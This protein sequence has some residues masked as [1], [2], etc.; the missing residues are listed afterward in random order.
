METS[1]SKLS[2][3]EW[4]QLSN[5]WGRGIDWVVKKVGRKWTPLECFG[6]KWPLYKT[7][8]EAYDTVTNLILEEARIRITTN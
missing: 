6:K 4:M 7:K 1:F 3:S 5:R 8:T 2:T